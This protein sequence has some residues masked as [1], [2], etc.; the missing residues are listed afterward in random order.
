M[1]ITLPLSFMFLTTLFGSSVGAG[2]S[3]RTVDGAAPP[4][5]NGAGSSSG[6]SNAS[7]SNASGG[8][9]ASGGAGGAGPGVG[10]TGVGGAAAP[11]SVATCQGKV[12]QCGDLLDNDGDGL[13]DS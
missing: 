9:D 2:C 5:D 10:T 11:T 4:G 3:D 7:G 1:R 13:I 8:S 6:G 12:Y